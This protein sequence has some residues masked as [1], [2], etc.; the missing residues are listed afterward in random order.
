[1]SCGQE[2]LT[3]SLLD[4]NLYEVEENDNSF[5]A[6]LRRSFYNETNCYLLFSDTLKKG[7]NTKV[8]KVNYTITK[9]GD[10]FYDNAFYTYA[11]LQNDDEKNKAFSFINS[12]VNPFMSKKEYPYAILLV[13]TIF[14]YKYNKKTNDYDWTNP[15]HKTTI[16]QGLEMTVIAKMKG[17]SELKENKQTDIQ[18]EIINSFIM[19]S[20]SK[21]DDKKF[22]KFYS[23]SLPYYDK[24]YDESS[25]DMPDVKDMKELGFIKAFSFQPGKKMYFYPKEKDKTVFMY[26]LLSMHETKWQ[27]KYREHTLVI[28]KLNALKTIIVD[29]LGYN[30]DY[31]KE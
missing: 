13:D 11:Y 25:T 6:K 28:N 31:L 26:E 3:P 16:E 24:S 19:R 29:D 5:E 30:L 1:M 21:L 7:D 14:R 12:K 10:D 8:L 2:E 9:E 17:I 4:K 18:K 23:Y 15:Y 20:L 22:N 27:K